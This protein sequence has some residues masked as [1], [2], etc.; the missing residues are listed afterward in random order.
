MT[1]KHLFRNPTRRIEASMTV[2]KCR[3]PRVRRIV[4][5]ALALACATAGP[6]MVGAP[7]SAD[8]TVRLPGQT[9]T[10]KLKDGTAVTI[11]RSNESARI[12]PSLGGTPLHRNAWVSG[13]YVVSTSDK[14]AQIGVGSGYI[15][16]CQLT[17]GGNSN[18]RSGGSAPQYDLQST[19][20]TAETGAGVTL[21]P[22][23]AVNYVITDREY[24]DAFGAA[25]HSSSIN[26]AG[27]KGTLAYTDETMMVNGCAGYAQARSYAKISVSTE[28]ASQTITVYGKP[29]SL[30]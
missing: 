5:S 1:A 23:Q 20:M 4:A 11:T 28:R 26:F 3:S 21:G 30:G 10:K 27:G 12:N 13:K 22:G 6:A 18:S 7:A 16:G 19:S 2:S 9:V 25:G 14:S 29:F 17:L 8:T 24:K 15:V